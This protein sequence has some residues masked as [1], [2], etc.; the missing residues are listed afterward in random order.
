[1]A[2]ALGDRAG[3]ARACGNL[4]NC[5]DSTRDCGRARELH[6]QH[7]AMAEALGDRAGVAR[8]CGNLGICYGHTGDYGRAIA[9]FT[10]KYNMAK[11]MQVEIQQAEAA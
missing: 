6:E 10:Q 1:M 7:R 5:Y 4:G 11:E 9:Y 8:A 3:V 2:E